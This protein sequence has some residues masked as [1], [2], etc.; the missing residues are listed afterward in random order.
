MC[1][2]FRFS[3]SARCD[4]II[5]E[6]K[7]RG[8]E[9]APTPTPAT[10]MWRGGPAVN[11]DLSILSQRGKFCYVLFQNHRNQSKHAKMDAIHP[12]G[13]VVQPPIRLL[14]EP[15]GH[16]TMRRRVHIFLQ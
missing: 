15:L 4:D 2:K 1:A 16:I 7:G 6:V 12:N 13:L 3:V 5:G 9:V 14:F 8:Q 10:G 11:C